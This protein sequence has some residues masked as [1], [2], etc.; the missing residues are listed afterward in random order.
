MNPLRSE[1]LER[2]F[3]HSVIFALD[4]DIQSDL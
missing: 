4:D 2:A 3:E 1:A